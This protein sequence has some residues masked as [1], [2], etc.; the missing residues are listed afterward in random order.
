M[1]TYNTNF[2]EKFGKM[3]DDALAIYTY[4]T[5]SNGFSFI[6]HLATVHA[7]TDKNV[8]I[9]SNQKDTVRR[10]LEVYAKGSKRASFNTKFPAENIKIIEESKKSLKTLSEELK[11]C[12]IIYHN[13]ELLTV[14]GDKLDDVREKLSENDISLWLCD[15]FDKRDPVIEEISDIILE[16][17]Y[18]IEPTAS[19]EYMYVKKHRHNK[20]NSHMRIDIQFKPYMKIETKEK[21]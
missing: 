3:Q 5:N 6:S 7:D 12:I 1:K 17:D 19:F 16:F 13:I 2:D 11:N 4:P 8:V 18:E 10:E 21:D 15:P 14:D 20:S 9:I